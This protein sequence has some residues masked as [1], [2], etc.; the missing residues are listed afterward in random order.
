[1]KTL[2]FQDRQLP[3]APYESVLDCLLRH[4][5]AVPYACKAGMCQACLVRAVD[6]VAT[7]ESRKW[8]KPELQA[9]GFTL[10]CQ[11][12]PEADACAALP[13]VADFALQAR[14][15][16]L[17]P[18]SDDVL[19]MDLALCDPLARFVCRPGQ[20]LTLTNPA[21][22]SRSYSLAN[23]PAR[24]GFLELHIT[25]TSHGLFTG[26]LFT[27]AA[28]GDLLYLRGP[29]GSCHYGNVE[30]ASTPL[31][32]AGNGTG[33]A[34]LY[35]IAREA[36]TRG[37][38]GPLLL[39]HGGRTEAQLYLQAELRALAAQHGN[40]RYLPCTLQPPTGNG[41][42]EGRIETLVEREL[43]RSGNAITRCQAF[44]CGSPSLVHALR[45]RLYLLGLR[46]ANIHCDPFTERPVAAAA[47]T[48]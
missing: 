22:I 44:V 45:K 46:A 16:R 24:D 23:D 26:W 6:C 4:G 31:L 32:L 21:G 17:T 43:Q 36:L 5:I 27:Q 38:Q 42:E 40:F 11:W 8:I 39:I 20:Y 12:V 15:L 34:P 25:R 33:L 13:D 28:A 35:G 9:R 30:E 29:H 48:D 37:H 14:L 2:K 41:I 1:M 47:T 10:A 3:L 7:A 18:L 19:R